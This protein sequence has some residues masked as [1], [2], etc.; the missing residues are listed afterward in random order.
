L[1]DGEATPAAPAPPARRVITTYNGVTYFEYFG[2][3]PGSYRR[4]DQ[5]LFSGNRD[6]SRPSTTELK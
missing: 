3:N 5:C 1:D 6:D 2:L 4:R